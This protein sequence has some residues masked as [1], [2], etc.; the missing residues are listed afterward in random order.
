MSSSPSS[1]RLT[2]TL[3]FRTLLSEGLLFQAMGAANTNQFI[4]MYI[5]DGRLHLASSLAGADAFTVA[6][7]GQYNDGVWHYVVATVINQTGNVDLDYG[8][9]VVTG[10]STFA[11][12]MQRWNLSSTVYFGGLPT[13][14][15]VIRCARTCMRVCIVHLSVTNLLCP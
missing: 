11:I 3:W 2:L 6:T 5:T 10:N 7:A 8:T 1:N 9:E 12:T 4:A 15:A 13:E 14:L